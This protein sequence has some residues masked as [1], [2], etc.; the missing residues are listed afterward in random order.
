MDSNKSSR[1]SGFTLIEILVVLS[2]IGILSSIGIA[3]YNTYTQQLILKNQARKIVDVF[4][5][6][7]KKAV[8]AELYQDCADFKGYRVV[9]SSSSFLLAFNCGGVYTTVQNFPM[10]SNITLITGTGNF[11]FLPLG[12]GDNLTINS[13]R[14][15]SSKINQCIDISI[16]PIGVLNINDTLISC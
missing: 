9:T 16:S 11:N 10:T 5:L 3:K 2:I 12:A 14:L 4:E 15:K 1:H 13:L 8:S 7:K 6:A